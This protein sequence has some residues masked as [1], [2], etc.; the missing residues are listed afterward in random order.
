[1]PASSQ[2]PPIENFSPTPT[3]INTTSSSYRSSSRRRPRPKDSTP[4]IVLGLVV[5]LIVGGGIVALVLLKQT[6]RQSTANNS[7][8]QDRSRST[9]RTDTSGQSVTE[10]VT[11]KLASPGRVRATVT[12]EYN[13]Y[14]GNKPDTDA[15]VTLVPKDYSGRISANLDPM[16]ARIT[17]DRTKS[18]LRNQGIYAGI[19]GGDGKALIADVPPGD[20]TIIIISKNTNEHPEISEFAEQR[21]AK[22]FKDGGSAKL[23]KIH[24]SDISVRSGEEVEY[25]HD[26]GNTYY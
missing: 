19:V 7:G 2:P 18:E 20:Y 12:W 10:I 13:K 3:S 22:Y 21:L 11:N 23:H 16:F 26:F 15:T 24:I 25:S 6:D 4:L 8:A 14:V 17:F 5:G 9:Q 1:M